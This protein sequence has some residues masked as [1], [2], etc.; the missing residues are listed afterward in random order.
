MSIS[1]KF[2][3]FFATAWAVYM[4]LQNYGVFE[5]AA[6]PKKVVNE[7]EEK[8]KQSRKRKFEQ[9]KLDLYVS[10]LEL[11]R[12]I[13]M[14]DTTYENH[15]YYIER[16]ELRTEHL[17]RL[18][19]P[20]EIRG[21]Y[22]LFLICGVVISPL[23]LFYPIV[24]A[25]PIIAL[26]MLFTYPTAFKGRI[27]EEDEIID[28]Y[29]IDLY[30]LLYSK[31]RQ[32]SRARLKGTVENYIDTLDGTSK[33]RE[34]QVML[35]LA[36]YFLNLL[37]L[38]EDHIAVPKLRDSYKS[39]TIINF[40]NVAT[41][42]LNGVDNFDNLLTFKMQLTDR[43]TNL[44]RKRQQ[45]ILA[46]GNRSIYAIWVILFIFIVVGWKSKLPTGLF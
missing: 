6:R 30:L 37:S 11:F 22:V 20:E 32:G 43:K 14:S 34:T 41:Q 42:S 7:V 21:K 33:T 16:L 44:M 2:I 25:V 18:L 38:Y 36:R 15:M 26:A 19:T 12:G 4:I 9:K 23:G 35:K 40:C 17:G 10:A 13:F 31:L 24:F 29:F 1:S 45:K 8:R 46:A 3:V 39:A 5:F 27:Q 28:D